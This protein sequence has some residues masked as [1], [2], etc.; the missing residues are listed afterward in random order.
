MERDERTRGIA[1]QREE[2]HARNAAPWGRDACERRRLARLDAHAPE[3]H[4][5][6]EVVLDHGLE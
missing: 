5:P 2:R 3:V 1:G 6:A 4:G